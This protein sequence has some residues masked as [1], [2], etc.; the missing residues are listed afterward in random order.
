M[1]SDGVLVTKTNEKGVY[2]LKSD[3]KYGYVFVSVPSGY[4]AP[5]DG[6][7]PLFWSHVSGSKNKAERI[8]FEL[9]KAD[10]ENYT[11]YLMGDMHI[12]G[13]A[14]CNDMVQY[15][16]FMKA[17]SE[18]ME[19]TPGAKYGL[20]LGDMSWDYY[21]YRA[22]YSLKNYAAEISKDLSSTGIT[23]YNTMG[24]HDNDFK[25]TGDFA[26]EN[27][28]RDDICPTYYSFNLGKVHFIVLDNIDYKNTPASEYDASGKI[29]KDHRSEYVYDFTADQMNWL[30][31]D[32][33]LVDKDTP[34]I[35]TAHAPVFRPSGATGRSAGCVQHGDGDFGSYD[36]L[37]AVKGYSKVL[38]F[39][40]HTHNYLVTDTYEQSRGFI[41]FNAGAVCGTWWWGGYYTEGFNLSPDGTPAGYTTLTVNGTDFKWKY[42]IPDY[43]DNYQFRAYDMNEVRKKYSDLSDT[44]DDGKWKDRWD[45]I[46]AGQMR[47]GDNT[48]LLNIWN[49]DSKWTLEVTDLETGEKLDATPVRTYDPLHLITNTYYRY[50]KT[51]AT[52]FVSD[53]WQHFFTVTASSAASDLEIKVT[54]RFGRVFTQTMERPLALDTENYRPNLY[55]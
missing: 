55:N 23:V 37:D 51:K 10:N 36:L 52:T 48:V 21:W 22:S 35:M 46:V 29:T 12:T 18:D 27:A 9:L 32:L 38:F 54:D 2:Q 7:M 42:D 31:K 24:N 44:F 47:M 5:V 19:A 33:A 53:S 28:Y 30:K 41:E 40:G 1:V 26:M 49:W 13:G 3:K 45:G 50:Y 11:L 43:S 17:M 25:Q 4:D 39:D 6:V 16:H 8:D 14:R 34:I 20:T 15:R